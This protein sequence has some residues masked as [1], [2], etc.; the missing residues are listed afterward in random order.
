[1]AS[2]AILLV[3]AGDHEEAAAIAAELEST[4]RPDYAALIRWKLGQQRTALVTL[5]AVATHMTAAC[6]ALLLP[7]LGSLIHDER[8]L[9]FFH[10]A[11]RS[12]VA[13]ALRALS[14]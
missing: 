11:G 1:M 9:D 6:I 8:F 10:G 12:D 4:D 13:H 14:D 2:L 7:G 5:A 3:D